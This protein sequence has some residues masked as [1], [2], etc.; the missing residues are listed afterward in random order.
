MV[1]AGRLGGVILA[2]EG[3]FGAAQA[4][5]ME[6]LVGEFLAPGFQGFFGLVHRCTS[7]A[8]KS[9]IALFSRDRAARMM[10]GFRG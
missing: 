10:R 6:L 9:P 4:A 2:G 7:L 8:E 1:D 3:A 5:D